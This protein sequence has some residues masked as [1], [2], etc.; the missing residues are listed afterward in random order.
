V[1]S[2]CCKVRQVRAVCCESV[3]QEE[4]AGRRENRTSQ[5]CWS[6]NSPRF[7]WQE[8]LSVVEKL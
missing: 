6:I 4:L 1:S 8:P 7:Y 3:E 5:K 2:V